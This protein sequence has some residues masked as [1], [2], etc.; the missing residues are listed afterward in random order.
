MFE[1]IFRPLEALGQLFTNR[2]LDH[3]L[4]SEADEGAGFGELD[5]A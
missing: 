1:Q 3:A 2:L 4:T 5:I